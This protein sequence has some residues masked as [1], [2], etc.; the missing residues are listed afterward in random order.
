MTVNDK[1]YFES[2]PK[3]NDNLYNPCQWHNTFHFLRLNSNN[4]KF[5]YSLT[6][7]QNRLEHD[8]LPDT[9]SPQCFQATAQDKVSRCPGEERVADPE[10]LV[11]V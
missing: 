8:K 10:R 2:E 1:T 4:R 11:R 5:N 9:T 7:I 3:L 6:E